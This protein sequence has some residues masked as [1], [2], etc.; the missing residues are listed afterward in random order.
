MR[1]WWEGPMK[2]WQQEYDALMATPEGRAWYR[3]NLVRE[4]PP[5]FIPVEPKSDRDLEWDLEHQMM[6]DLFLPRT[7]QVLDRQK[8]KEFVI[9]LLDVAK[10]MKRSPE[11]ANLIRPLVSQ[12]AGVNHERF[13]EMARER[14]SQGRER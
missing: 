4:C 5:R 8:Q 12:I 13:G 6:I 9:F 10:T 11:F 14:P 1:A 2:T 3:A 7:P